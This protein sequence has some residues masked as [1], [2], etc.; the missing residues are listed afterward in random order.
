MLTSA[1][2]VLSTKLNRPPVTGDRIDRPR[3]IDMLNRGLSGPLSLVSAAAGFGKTTLVSSW[4]EGLAAEGRPPTPS[5]WLSLD[6]NDSDLTVFLRYFV[7]AIRAIFPESCADTLA[8]LQAPQPASPAFFVIALSNDIERLPTRFV[9]VL[10]DYNAIYGAAVHDFLSELIRHWPQR[11]HLVLI[12][13][14]N[15]PLPLANLRATGRVS[16]IRTRDLR[17]TLEESAAFLAKVLAVPISQSSVALLDQNVEGWIAGLRLATLSLRTAVDIE[18]E[19][20]NWSGST[21]EIA[22]YLMDQVLSH[23]PPELRKFLLA[24]SILD[25]LCA[26]LCEHVVGVAASNDSP[27]CDVPV[28]IQR[29]ESANLFV[30]PLNNDREWYRYHHLFRDLL[31]RRLQ[32]EV[33]PERVADLH[34]AAAS[35]FAGQG[36]L[37][38]AL[39]H[40]LTVNDF[41]LAA[42]L[43]QSG[44]CDVLNRE[45]RL[46]L[47]RWLRLL[48]ENFAQRRPWLLMIK[49]FAFQFSSR[50]PAVWKLLGQIEA[51]VDEGGEA[52]FHVGDAHDLHVLRGLVAAL[53]SQKAFSNNQVASALAYCEE[54]FALLPEQWR[55]AR[56]GALMFWGMSM[57]ATGQGEAAHRRLMEEYE[58]TVGKSDAYTLRILFTVCLNS[59]ETGNLEQ[60]R[61][62]AHVLREQAALSQLAI[63]EGWAHYFLGAVH[64]QWNELDIATRHFEHI[65]HRRYSVHTQSARNGMI[66][67]VWVHL[68]RLEFAKA[69]QMLELLSQ[70]DIERM[71][72]ERDDTRSLRGQL[73]CLQ[74]D[75]EKASRWADAFTDP[76]PDRLLNWL[77]DPHLAKA[78]ILLARGSVADVQAALDILDILSSFA[79]R[80]FNIRFQIE[81]LTLRALALDAQRKAVDALAALRQALELARPGGFMRVFVDR[82]PQMQSMLLNLAGQGQYVATVRRILA[83]FPTT[84]G[85]IATLQSEF[86]VHTANARLLEPLTGRELEVLSL[87]PE[88]LSNK[89][90]AHR[91]GLSPTTVKRHTVNLY[92]KLGVN[93][94]WDAVVKAEVLEILLRR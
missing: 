34:R 64:Y 41:D 51:M 76:P 22:D 40:A 71:G 93:K 46:T 72:E 68:A 60:V 13:R 53:R 26:A 31:R 4:V 48:P 3:L 50:L 32:A 77:Q 94:R 25:R 28:C 90:I 7:A 56:G 85:N 5:A 27:P 8:L 10:D 73:E 36:L 17:F 39:R 75:T 88:R 30:I 84:H 44:L 42:Q 38:E 89:E 55:Y 43:M 61:Q 20:A 21:A 24:T 80:T 78:Q 23:Q 33:G 47:D 81:T 2:T 57:R 92:S 52:T 35:W 58:S 12:S 70:L 79:Q 16:E 37:E 67:L 54:A 62:V 59:F 29:L 82:G 86:V 1:L 83:L 19:L 45:D 49:A 91:L 63:L 65:V 69:R 6:E 15:P 66:G 11:M 87:L 9:L 74:G 14:S 18:S